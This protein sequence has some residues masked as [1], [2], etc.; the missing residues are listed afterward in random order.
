M[1]LHDFMERIYSLTNKHTKRSLSRIVHESHSWGRTKLNVFE[2][3]TEAQEDQ[4]KL[5]N[6]VKLQHLYVYINAFDLSRS[7]ID[8]QIPSKDDSKTHKDQRH[9]PIALLSGR[10]DA[11]QL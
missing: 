5:S 7:G 6:R 9:S 10:F 2:S 1:L 4:V 8:N 11:T 3:C